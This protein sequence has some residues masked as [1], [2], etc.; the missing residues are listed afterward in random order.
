MKATTLAVPE[1]AMPI[2]V[3]VMPHRA[4]YSSIR[5]GLPPLAKVAAI[6]VKITSE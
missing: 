5:A 2:R 6:M 1:V 3:A 4:K